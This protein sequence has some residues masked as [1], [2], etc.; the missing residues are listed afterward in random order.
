MAK[1][2]FRDR[3]TNTKNSAKMALLATFAEY[4]DLKFSSAI[5][6]FC[7]YNNGAIFR[8]DA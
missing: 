3:K 8:G 2:R 4:K 7:V 1:Q 6:E 5:H